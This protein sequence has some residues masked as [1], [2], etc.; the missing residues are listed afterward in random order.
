MR[1]EQTR[2][3]SLV[4]TSLNTALGFVVS[5]L[6]WPLVA[7]AFGY[8]YSLAHNLGIT[9]I[10][11]CLSVARGYMVRRFF[12]SHFHNIAHK[13]GTWYAAAKRRKRTE[14]YTSL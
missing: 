8:P 10:F 5:A 13:V 7:H 2:V 11:T 14:R 6:D 3:E 1:P 12:N 9:G 4:E